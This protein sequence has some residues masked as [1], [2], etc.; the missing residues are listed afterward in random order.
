MKLAAWAPANGVYPQ[1]TDR[2]FRQGTMPVPA[3]RLPSG[4]I[5]VDAP[6]ALRVTVPF[7]MYGSAHRTKLAEGQE[8]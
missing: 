1:T 2:W 3:R 5:L 7:C 8:G 6:T 4:T